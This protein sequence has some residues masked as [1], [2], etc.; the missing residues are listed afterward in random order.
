M[1]MK[2][3]GG[4]L[5]G[6]EERNKI[7]TESETELINEILLGFYQVSRVSI[8]SSSLCEVSKLKSGVSSSKSQAQDLKLKP[9]GSVSASGS[10]WA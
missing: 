9:Q 5:W 3:V 4:R 7:E 10:A 8:L 1:V 6:A 2:V